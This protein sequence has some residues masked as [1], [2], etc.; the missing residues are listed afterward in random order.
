MQSS[1][2]ARLD[3]RVVFARVK[4]RRMRLPALAQG[5][6]SVHTTVIDTPLSVLM[7]VISSPSQIF[8]IPYR[9][10]SVIP[11]VLSPA[12]TRHRFVVFLKTLSGTRGALHTGATRLG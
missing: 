9:A 1:V 12:S 11:G 6:Q 5:G 4:A 7:P 8:R 3:H 2:K 10:S